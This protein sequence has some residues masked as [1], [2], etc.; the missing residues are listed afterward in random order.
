MNDDD[1]A[2]LKRGTG[3]WRNVETLT[4]LNWEEWFESIKEVSIVEKYSFLLTHTREQYCHVY[5][6][7]RK[8]DIGSDWVEFF[9]PPTSTDPAHR[10]WL[11]SSLRDAYDIAESTFLLNF[12]HKLDDS[13]KARV[14][15]IKSVPEKI[16][17]LRAK[18]A[19]T[20]SKSSSA[21]VKAFTNWE[22]NTKVSPSENFV[23]MFT[24]RKEAH[25]HSGETTFSDDFMWTTFLSGLRP[26]EAYETLIEGFSDQATQEYMLERLDE[27]WERVSS[28]R[29][30][31]GLVALSSTPPDTSYVAYDRRRASRS[32]GRRQSLQ[33]YDGCF[34]CGGRHKGIACPWA[35][36]AFEWAK[37]MRIRQEGELSD[38]DIR[39]YQPI[40]I[41]GNK[42]PDR[43]A[44]YVSPAPK[45]LSSPSRGRSGSGRRED[46][47]KSSNWRARGKS[48]EKGVTFDDKT[49]LAESDSD[50]EAEFD[51]FG[52]LSWERRSEIPTTLAAADSGC[53]SHMT[54]VGALFSEAVKP[55]RRR[56]RVG[57]G[58]IWSDG[59]GTAEIRLPNG[60]SIR[61]ADTLLV[62]GLGCTLLSAKKLSSSGLIGEFDEH[63]MIFSRRADRV[64]MIEATVQNGLYIVSWI[65][66]EADG[67]TFRASKSE[68][69]TH[70]LGS[71]I[72]LAPSPDRPHAQRGSLSAALGAVEG[73][74][75][76]PYSS[77]SHVSIDQDYDD[78]SS[79]DDQG[80]EPAKIERN[81]HGEFPTGLLKRD[82]TKIAR[83]I[84]KIAHRNSQRERPEFTLKERRLQKELSRYVYYHRRF[85]H[86]S[87]STLALLHTVCDIKKIVIPQELPK[88]ETCSRQKIHKRQSKQLAIHKQEP[89]A[90]I[91]F[92]VA[93]PFPSSY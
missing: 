33:L 9:K 67:M 59:I 39:S 5:D 31:R 79:A 91:N 42:S 24:I 21:R 57:G 30:E 74:P 72:S 35:E 25:R 48:T 93:G 34:K 87:P 77:I 86:A 4:K 2:N 22:M 49:Y 45:R 68:R 56:I 70:T 17:K 75:A 41:R 90:L 78:N 65:A 8:Q 1:L 26:E 27:K 38:E 15:G 14:K 40:R 69:L 28:R 44:R 7:S 64:P 60:R 16:A 10:W 6:A 19:A 81:E 85:C 58:V 37:K 36:G 63:R 55:C 32:P 50:S 89:L 84:R 43:P 73:L 54:D 11:I 83:Q 12:R 76:A 53:T 23:A 52:G 82:R 29:R 13:D 92:D 3:Q 61:L 46:I 80:G 88:C 62:P 66:Q 47:A 71:T 51:E 18:Y 20:T